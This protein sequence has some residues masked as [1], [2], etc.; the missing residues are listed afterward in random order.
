MTVEKL[1]ELL[2]EYDLNAEVVI[3]RNQDQPHINEILTVGSYNELQE[4]VQADH[5]NQYGTIDDFEMNQDEAFY[6]T[7]EEYKVLPDK[8]KVIIAIDNR[9]NRA[10]H[11]ESEAWYFG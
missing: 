3:A 5:E 7:F 11:V 8:N 1:I 9:Y 6:P 4:D 10:D 2:M